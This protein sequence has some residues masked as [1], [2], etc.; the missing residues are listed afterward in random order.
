[1]PSH[2]AARALPTLPDQDVRRVLCVVAH[3]DDM[4]YGASAAVHRWTARGVEVT[5]LLLTAGEAGMAESPEVVAP[6][7]AREQRTA[8]TTV[9]VEDLRIL[10]HP[11]GMLEPSLDLR[12]DVARTV[13]DVRPDL[14]LTT[15]YEVEAYGSL[16]QADHRAAGTAA[17]DG[18]RDAANPWVF[19]EL[20]HDGY[21]PWQARALLVV[22]HSRPTH[23]IPVGPDD[24]EAS[25]ASLR[26]HEAYLAHVT[27]H[28]APEELIPRALQEGGAQAEGGGLAVTARV[29]DLG[30]LGGTTGE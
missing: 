5:Y 13:R 8:C 18:T 7:R 6:L 19:R 9:G 12:R 4:E 26:S 10:A 1:M 16:N 30:G 2:Q 27:G 20:G 24:A 23:A 25:I 29:F 17:A 21:R 14:V 11:D 22:G 15:T 3:P 28:P